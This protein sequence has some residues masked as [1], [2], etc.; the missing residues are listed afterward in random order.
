MDEDLFTLPSTRL[1][2]AAWEESKHPRDAKGRWTDIVTRE[3][4]QA[5]IS[6][7]LTA[8]VGAAP[9]L[10]SVMRSARNLGAV[11]QRT[12]RDA[13]LAPYRSAMRALR[14]T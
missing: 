1:S 4:G 9:G 3:V 11:G 10:L 13:F 5:A 2:K 8:L 7:G 14:R 6:A 12:R